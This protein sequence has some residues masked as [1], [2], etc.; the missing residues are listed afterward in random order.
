SRSE[1]RD[2]Y[3]H[4]DPYGCRPTLFRC[5]MDLSLRSRFQ[6]EDSPFAARDPYRLSRCRAQPPRL[7]LCT[8][9]TTS[10]RAFNAS[11]I[12]RSIVRQC[13]EGDMDPS[14]RS[15]FQKKAQSQKKLQNSL[16]ESSR[17][18]TGP[19][20]TSSTSIMAWKTPVSQRRLAARIRATK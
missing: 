16:S 9:S 15:G 10:G 5:D 6:K 11:L 1:A 7:R 3:S 4:P 20:F 8:S 14:L 18:V 17:I 2:P 12:R 13:S 19:S